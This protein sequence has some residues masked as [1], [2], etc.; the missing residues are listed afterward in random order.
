MSKQQSFQ[1]IGTLSCAN[2]VELAIEREKQGKSYRVRDLFTNAMSF[3][4]SEGKAWA[5]AAFKAQIDG[6][7][8]NTTGW[9]G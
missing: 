2:G 9:K 3:A 5:S 7:T 4:G 8:H 6:R 1:L